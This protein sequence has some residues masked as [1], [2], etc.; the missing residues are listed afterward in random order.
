M[1]RSL[2]FSSFFR[3][4]ALACYQF[5]VGKPQE[6]QLEFPISMTQVSFSSLN[7]EW[8]MVDRF[9]YSLAG[10]VHSQPDS[11][12]Y[13]RICAGNLFKPSS[14]QTGYLTPHTRM[15][16]ALTRNYLLPRA[17]HSDSSYFLYFSRGKH[18]LFIQFTTRHENN[19]YNYI[20]VEY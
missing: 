17:T 3:Q 14:P 6:S 2:I 20:A 15:G 16:N 4:T 7:R 19:V 12:F 13:A 10:A 18:G 9:V 8:D 1:L 5:V 11:T